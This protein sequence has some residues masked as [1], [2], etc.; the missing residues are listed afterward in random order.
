MYTRIFTYT[1]TYIYTLLIRKHK[2]QIERLVLMYTSAYVV[3]VTTSV[4]ANPPWQ[5]SRPTHPARMD[6]IAASNGVLLT[7]PEPHLPLQVC[8]DHMS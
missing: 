4:P 8:G 1:Y 6:S 5:P 7:S 3:L 2:K